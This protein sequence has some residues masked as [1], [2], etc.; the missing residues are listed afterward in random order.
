[1]AQGRLPSIVN[2]AVAKGLIPKAGQ[3]GFINVRLNAVMASFAIGY[4]TGSLLDQR[5][6]LSARIS[7]GMILDHA[8]ELTFNQFMENRGGN[9]GLKDLVEFQNRCA[10]GSLSAFCVG[11]SS[12]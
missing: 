4:L 2:E 3:G 12:N 5:F 7:D 6:C 11:F 10:G 1:M 8:T 9:L